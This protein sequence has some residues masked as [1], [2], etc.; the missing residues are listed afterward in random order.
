MAKVNMTIRI[1]PDL[2]AKVSSLFK[3]LGMDLNTATEVFYRQALRQRGL[4]FD[5]RLD[6]PNE[7]TYETIEK[8][9]RNEEIFGPFDCVSDLMEALN[10]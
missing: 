9:E 1:E 2:K 8:A 4:P 6:E 5:V 3:S 10:A 7:V